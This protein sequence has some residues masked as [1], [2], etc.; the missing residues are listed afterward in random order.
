M[1][2][3][4]LLIVSHLDEIKRER[5]ARAAEQKKRLL[6]E[7]AAKLDQVNHDHTYACFSREVE[8]STF[9]TNDTPTGQSH[10]MQLYNNEVVIDAKLAK[11]LEEKT[12]EQSTSDLWHNQRKTASIMKEVCH[13]KI[14]TSCTAFIKKKFNCMSLNTTAVLYGR[15][16]EKNA[17]DS[18]V[19]YKVKHGVAI[20]VRKCGLVVD[21]LLPWLAASPD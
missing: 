20:E 18:Y 4:P 5:I 11:E 10:G 2:N 13:R 14:S 17:I 9:P 16:H 8:D 6:G 7:L 19:D 15:E 3:Q 12:R 21:T 1:M